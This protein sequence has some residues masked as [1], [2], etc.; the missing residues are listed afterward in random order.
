MADAVNEAGPSLQAAMT[1]VQMVGAFTGQARVI[2]TGS[3]VIVGFGAGGPVARVGGL[4]AGVRDLSMSYRREVALAQHLAARGAP[5]GL[6]WQPAGPFKQADRVISLWHEAQTEP[7]ADPSAAGTNLR[8]CHDALRD[9]PD[10]LPPLSSLFDE[11][12]RIVDSTT[13]SAGDQRVF[14]R[15]ISYAR[16]VLIELDLPE[17]PLHGDAGMGNVLTGGVWHDWEDSCR[18]PLIWDLASLISSARIIGREPERADATL[19]AYG[20]APGLQHIDAF[21]AIRGLHVLAWSLLASQEEG[22]LRPTTEARLH[23]LR[24]YPWPE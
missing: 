9:F 10:L 20:D 11:A 22:H 12:Q 5:V 8:L 21:V 1:V 16:R 2:Y 14:H 4:T 24:T 3:S 13:V 6:P 17:Q 19:L 15:A 23:W 7:P 18:G